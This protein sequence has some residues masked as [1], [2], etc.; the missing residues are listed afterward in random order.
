MAQE[1]NKIRQYFP[2]IKI[3]TMSSDLKELKEGGGTFQSKP[4][5][6]LK[7]KTDFLFEEQKPAEAEIKPPE[8]DLQAQP[9]PEPKS[10]A[11]QEQAPVSPGDKTNLIL[12][13]AGSVLGA[14]FIGSLVFWVIYPE[15]SK[16]LVGIKQPSPSPVI[17]EQPSP[18]PSP[19]PISPSIK[20]TE[21]EKVNLV[22]QKQTSSELLEK[23]KIE[24]LLPKESGSLVTYD[25]L[26]SQGKYLDSL[27]LIELIAPDAL[28][29]FKSAPDKDYLIFTYWL[30]TGESK[31]GL[32]LSLRPETLASVKSILKSWETANVEEYF[33]LVFL[34]ES[35]QKRGQETFKD[36]IINSVSARKI[37]LGFS[38]FIYGFLDNY[39]IISSNEQVF[40]TIIP[41]INR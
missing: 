13:I 24:T 31:T 32:V 15:I 6:K 22:L 2:N 35:P 9:I 7:D 26:N 18:S 38:E 33:P 5:E 39:L 37:K 11:P 1:N 10:T 34:P 17:T 20:L 3:R 40:K 41:L 8:L 25:F 36:V 23:L 27:S 16:K 14:I 19:S 12:I 21:A 29:S 4:E 28:S 30:E